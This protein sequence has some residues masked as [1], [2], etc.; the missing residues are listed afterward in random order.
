M[1]REKSIGKHLITNMYS[2]SISGS[3]FSTVHWYLATQYFN[4]E[5]K[6]SHD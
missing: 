1:S 3:S 6:G 5:A 2:A 4:N